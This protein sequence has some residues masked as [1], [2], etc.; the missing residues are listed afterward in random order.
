MDAIHAPA[1]YSTYTVLLTYYYKNYDNDDTYSIL[2]LLI[3]T[4]AHYDVDAHHLGLHLDANAMNR[5]CFTSCPT[6]SMQ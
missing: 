5:C 3:P 2:M 4:Y 1:T 6:I